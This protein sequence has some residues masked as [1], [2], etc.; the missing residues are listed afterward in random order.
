MNVPNRRVDNKI[1]VSNISIVD[2]ALSLEI[3][4]ILN[5]SLKQAICTFHLYWVGG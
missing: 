5:F 1:H 2:E 3:T 4:G